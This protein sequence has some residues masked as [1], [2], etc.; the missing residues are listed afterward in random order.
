MKNRIFIAGIF[1]FFKHRSLWIVLACVWLAGCA[2][3]TRMQDSTPLHIGDTTDAQYQVMWE[4]ANSVIPKYFEIKKADRK[5]GVVVT[6]T[7]V[8][9]D[10]QGKETKRAFVTLQHADRG[11]DIKVEIPYLTY[12]RYQNIYQESEKGGK[13]IL[14]VEKRKLEPPSKTDVYL[15][16]LIRDEI[17]RT[18]KKK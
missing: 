1:S 14:I 4:A 2:A 12:D 13:K 17:L 9:H 8:D 5:K 10:V 7:R 11:Y 6:E 18:A 3:P 16:A 15:E